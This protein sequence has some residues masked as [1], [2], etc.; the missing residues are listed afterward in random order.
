MW[1][2]RAPGGE[3]VYSNAAFSQIMRM[4]PVADAKVGGYSEPYGIF[5][6]DGRPYPE[7]QMPFVRALKARTT[8]MV[9]DLVIHRGDGSRVPVRAFGK[10]LLGPGGDVELVMISFFD[11]TAEAHAMRDSASARALL[12]LAVQH[13]PVIIWASDLDGIITLSEG[14][15]LK[16]LGRSSGELIGRS[17]FELYGSTAGVLENRRRAL[18]GESVVTPPFEVGGAV[19]EGWLGP[20][21]GA[22]GKVSGVIG[23]QTDVTESHR[24]TERAARADRMVAMGTMAA[25]VA[26][27]INNPLTYVLEGLRSMEREVQGLA[28]ELEGTAQGTVRSRLER[29]LRLLPEVKDG[30]EH[31]RVITSDLQTFS[32]PEGR[33]EGSVADVRRAG[34]TAVQMLATQIEA[35]ARFRVELGEAALVRGSGA[36]L[37]QI[38]VNLL[39]NAVQALG[40]GDKARD[41]IGIAVRGD[42]DSV[43]IEVSDTGPGIPVNLGDRIFE[44]FVTTK[45]VG[46]GTGL[47]LFVCRNLVHELG[48]TI[49]A[50]NRPQGGAV[51]RVRLPRAIAE[52]ETSP[53]PLATAARR[54]R[55]LIIDDNVNLGRVMAQ[56][57]EH[58]R[59][60]SEVVHT[61][62]EAIER[63]A[64]GDAFDV[65]FCDL[66]MKDMTGMDVFVELQ[67]RRPGAE[68]ALVFMTGGAF[69]ERARSFLASV[70]NPWLQKP[71]DVCEQLSQLLG[72]RGESRLG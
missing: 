32:R 37:V 23:V 62:R 5:G 19:L 47:G 30:A 34:E 26:H 12:E 28:A 44:P 36:R 57:L 22:D 7:D 49:E 42:G 20:L 33:V 31:V 27:E 6:R 17:V 69:T 56:A 58:E 51:L 54:A 61:G 52:A 38:F 41:E 59:H 4:G 50:Q 13:A 2:A 63:L 3:F 11:I 68:A 48:G 1:V 64:A 16:R 65:V 21:R 66:M 25:S 14:A 39:L 10:P 35:K 70:G 53:A 8:V 60:H 46:E 72:R 24:A 45:P 29:L 55:V 71:F 40:D 43:V 18:S 67:R 15:G 9:D